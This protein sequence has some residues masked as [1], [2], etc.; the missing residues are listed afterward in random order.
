MQACQRKQIGLCRGACVGD[1]SFEDYE[2][3]FDSMFHKVNRFFKED[4][5]IE[6]IGR[7]QLEKSIIIIEKDFAVI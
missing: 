5:I 6:D 2:E 7:N 4:L 1:E 3:R